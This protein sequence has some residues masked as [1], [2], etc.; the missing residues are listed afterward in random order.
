MTCWVCNPVCD[1][2]KPKFVACSACGERGFL[3]EV[4]CRACGHEFTDE[5][6]DEARASWKATRDTALKAKVG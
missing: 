2:C 4:R 6:R 1:H 3:N 5:E